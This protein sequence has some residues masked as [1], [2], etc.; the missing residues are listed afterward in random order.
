MRLSNT[1]PGEQPSFDADCSRESGGR[2]GSPS[3]AGLARRGALASDPHRRTRG[4]P[5][6]AGFEVWIHAF[7]DGRDTPPQSALGFVSEFERSIA[8]LARARIATVSG[9][10]Y[11]M[12]R[13]KRWDRVAKAYAAMVDAD[14]ARFPDARSAVTKSYQAGVTDEFVVPCVI[15]GYAGVRDKDALFFANFRPDRARGNFDPRCSIQIRG[16]ARRAWRDS[17]PLRE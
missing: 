12:D 1:A 10:Y 4:H 7:L 6:A 15:G 2:R 9:R 16:F 5:D 11:A 13:D 8:K 3:G 14:G 17:R